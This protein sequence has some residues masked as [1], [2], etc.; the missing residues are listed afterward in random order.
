MRLLILTVFLLTSGLAPSLAQ[1]NL[2]PVF[3]QVETP[4]GTRQVRVFVGEK[5]SGEKAPEST[6]KKS[7]ETTQLRPF[8]TPPQGELRTYVKPNATQTFRGR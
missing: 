6:E 1:E 5:P 3:R 2:K 4:E 8:L 7:E